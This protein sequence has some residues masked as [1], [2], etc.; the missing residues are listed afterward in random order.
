MS[1]A[2]A[3]DPRDVL[4]RALIEIRSLKQRLT[5]AEQATSA[6]P[7][8][9]EPIAV[10]G[11]GCRFA[12]G[13]DS[14]ASFWKLLIEGHDA[15]RPRPAGRWRA[16][17][18][19]GPACGGFLDD[20]EGFDARLFEI[21]PREAAAMD[22]QHRLLLEVAWEALEH[23]AIDAQALAGSRTGVFIG[24]ATNDFARLVP[25]ASVDRYFGVGSSPAV[26]SG[27]L[28]YLFDLRG[29]CLTIDTACSSSLVAVHYAMRALR[30]RD[31]DLALAGGASLML[32]PELGAS[33]AAAGMLAPDGRCK[34]F[35]AAADGYGRGEGAGILVLRRLA[36]ALAAGD[37]V[38]AVLQGSAI[39]QDGRS[40]G[41]TAPNGPAQT[42]LIG[43]ALADARLTVDDIDYV[44]THG[45]GTPL[46]DPI[47]WHALA[48]AF[49]GRQ[50]TLRIGAVK[51][52]IGHTEA[53]AGIAGLIKAVLAVQHDLL[54]PSL[55]FRRRNPAIADPAGLIE[56]AVEAV[57]GVRYAGVSSFGFSGTNAHVVVGPPPQRTA[58]A[59]TGDGLLL[60]TARDPPALHA[61]ADRYRREFAAGLDFLAA[62][63]T[64]ATGRARLPWWIAVRSPGELATAT[65]ANGPPPTSG[66]T[67]GP[68]VALPTYP[69]QRERF[70]LPGARPPER[71]LMP[72]DPLLAGSDGLAHLGVLLQ[73][74]LDGLGEPALMLATVTF[75]APLAVTT[76]RHVRTARDGDAVILESRGSGEAEWT[77]HLQAR[78]LPA[79]PA[80]APPPEAATAEAAPAEE[81]YRRIAAC[82]FRY[83]AESCRMDRVAA[84]E[85]VAFGWL[86]PATAATGGGEVEAAAQLA[87]AL[88]PP[89]AAPVMLASAERLYWRPAPGSTAW[90]ERLHDTAGGGDRGFLADLGLD[91]ED[92]AAVL[93]IDAAVF[94]PLPDL[95]ARWS[96]S[97]AWVPATLPPA[98]P[99]ENAPLVWVAPEH[100]AD[101]ARLCAALLQALPADSTC[102]LRIVT[103]GAQV[104][105]AEASPPALAQAAL[106]GLAQAIIA[107]RPALKTRLIDLDPD[108]PTA[109]QQEAL[110]AEGTADDEPAVAWRGGCRLARRLA[111]PARPRP[112]GRQARIPAPGHIAWQPIGEATLAAGM[113]RVDVVAAGLT[114]RDRLLFNGMA[115]A[116]SRLGADC[117]GI[118]AAVGP[119]V[120]S[121]RP[122]DAVVAICPEAIA[123]SVV[124]PEG[125][126][127]PAPFPDLVAAA[128]MPVPYLTAL[129]GLGPLGPG[130]R[131]LVHQAGSATGLAALAV[132][133]RTG[134]A[135]VATAA[136]QRHAWFT[137]DAE[138]V[139][140]SRAPETWQK[141]LAGV[142]VAFGAFDDALAAR[143]RPAR[144]VNLNKSAAVHFDLDALATERLRALLRELPGLPPLPRQIVPRD[145]LAEALAGNGPLVGRSIVLLREPP[146]ARIEPGALYLVT[147]AAGALGGLVADWLM[148]QGARLCLVDRAPV[149]A[150]APHLAVTADCGDAAAMGALFRSLANADAPLRGVFHCAAITDD[151]PL[152]RQTSER[153]A[154]VL[155]AKVDGAMLLDRLTRLHCFGARQLH[156]FVLFSSLVASVPSARQGAYAAANAVLDQLAQARRQRGLPG[157]SLAWGPWH[158]GIGRAMG[159]RAVTAWQGF[160]VRPI[161]PA[162]GLRALPHLLAAP[163]A[164]LVVTDKN[165]A[166]KDWA[167]KDWR[168]EDSAAASDGE[169]PRRDQPG[170]MTVT[171]LQAILAPLLGVRDPA[172]LDA[173]VPLT[174][175]GFDS[176]TAVEFAR[177]LSRE[178]GRPVPPDFA[179]S[180]PTLAEA[181]TALAPPEAK[182]RPT[183]TEAAMPQEARFVLLRPRWETRPA[184]A[185]AARAWQ[186]HREGAPFD[187]AAMLPTEPESGNIADLSALAL[188]PGF[189]PPQ[190]DRWFIA[191]IERLRPHFGRP[192]RLVLALPDAEPLAAAIEGFAAALSAE[193]RLWQVRTIRLDPAMPE[194]PATLARE[195]AADDG[196]SRVRLVPPGRQVLRLRPAPAGPGWRPDPEATYLVTGGSG[197]IGSLVTAHLVRRGARHLALASR[198]PTVPPFLQD[199]PARVGL[200][201]VDL[202]EPG[203]AET[204]VT[205][206]RRQSP[207]LAGI[208]HIAGRSADGTLAAAWPRLAAAFP[209]KADAAAA[210][211]E[212]AADL[213]LAQ[214]VLFSS[215][216]AWFG[217]AGTAGYAAA[218]GYLGGLAERRAAE[219]RCGQAIAWCA[220]QGVGMAA[221]PALWQ[222]GRAPSLPEAAALAA[223][224][225]AL[226]S[227]E[228]NLVVVDRTWL[229]AANSP[230]LEPPLRSSLPLASDG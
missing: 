118:V 97:V 227:G 145:A 111:A 19:S 219:G 178:L 13:V 165:W 99:S 43:M 160:G 173:D 205:A 179:Y 149:Q 3:S 24:L 184:V 171:R 191:L 10:I 74:L 131:V 121:L 158:A 108:L 57:A 209:A 147:G 109:A 204:L 95:G 50:R 157:L 60:L 192:M 76:P 229:E 200:H 185:F 162:F 133:K 104:T 154:A 53:A 140:D 141:A 201:A 143:L 48:A 221:D 225:T 228:A 47:E 176:L 100:E 40:A 116:G 222:G 123:D 216:A 90:C 190:R 208:F 70:P 196:E 169:Q 75:A 212:A 128:T 34:S 224:D 159:T 11:I 5:A 16:A 51:S 23:A 174:T 220:W 78:L 202:A 14:P 31:C 63:H 130:D 113:V 7:P 77:A 138:V 4:R 80:P 218:N 30:Q 58:P 211:A 193:Q 21:A 39:N 161:L 155:R 6:A 182:P 54:P 194:A 144:I 64:A 33:F 42:A 55:N 107:E 22:P 180:H 156:H 85:D 230:L 105:G 136:R 172:T 69:F 66:P 101:P 106:W 59:A 45:T 137:A 89:Y 152:D 167:D 67:S 175:L 68:R 148:L 206:L 49:A 8:A 29:P 46:G 199:G 217:L 15:I 1:D 86:K 71:L 226:G 87:Y 91:G 115:P 96:R 114:F 37:P 72:E 198:G 146:P 110:A 153:I 195:L 88:L 189:A 215:T 213:D 132:A 27:R 127:A 203:G 183:P 32:G 125:A 83:G 84:A 187:L 44:E 170:P 20:V 62:C 135:V 186:V 117:A 151:D 214:F 81:L 129:A 134:A 122:G 119:G 79:P 126:V 65:P 28:A 17:N 9:P 26:A 93:R 163:E 82:G 139:L 210:L 12:G 207:P 41:L 188:P 73:L 102:R 223:F 98:T 142:T 181:A 38:L 18:D 56:V 25:A 168:R 35:D 120:A 150:A 94:A 124:V 164:H 103:R 2:A 177:A 36:D 52:N 197:G 166:D 112:A 92:G 61:L